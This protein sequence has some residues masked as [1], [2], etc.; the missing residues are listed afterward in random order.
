MGKYLLAAAILALSGQAQAAI[1]N[2]GNA[3]SGANVA[4]FGFPDSQTY[5]QVFTA[6]VSDI[7]TSFTL[8]LGS[9][10]KGNMVGVLGTWNGTAAW[11]EGFGSPSTLYTSLPTS[12]SGSGAFTFN[13]NVNVTVGKRYVAYITVF[14]QTG[15]GNTNMPLGDDSDPW[16]DYFVW[17]NET[18]PYG[19]PSWNYFL[20]FGDAHFSAT[21]GTGVIPEPQSWVM[22]IAGFGLVGAAARRRRTGVTA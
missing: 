10:F 21:F 1:T 14:E 15:R 6:P 4:E 11:D 9:G 18:S 7:M 8:R 2:I 3:P 20:D 16:L 22:L 19:N 13:P 12:V 17:H 5:G